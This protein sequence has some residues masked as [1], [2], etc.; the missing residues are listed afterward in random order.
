MLMIKEGL[1]RVGLVYQRLTKLSFP[2]R[3]PIVQF[4]NLPLIVALLAGAAGRFLD[5]SADSYASAVSYLALT[6]WSYEELVDGVNWF[7]RLL[8][9]A[10]V[11]VLIVRVAHALHA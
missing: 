9:L 4:P 1:L 10:F 8:G 2:R 5:G 11:I 6:I 3:F 7:R